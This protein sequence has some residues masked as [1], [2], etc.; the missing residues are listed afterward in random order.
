MQAGAYYY[1]LLSPEKLL[2][3]DV[4][5]PKG[6]WMICCLHGHKELLAGRE[7]IGGALFHD[8]GREEGVKQKKILFRS[9]FWRIYGSDR[10]LEFL[11]SRDSEEIFV[12]Q[13]D[14]FEEGTCIKTDWLVW[15]ETRQG[16]WWGRSSGQMP[17]Y[18]FT[19]SLSLKEISLLASIQPEF[20]FLFYL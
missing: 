1:C 18:Y 16:M 20:V 9:C 7:I 13:E 2:P 5:I 3:A 8:G 4:T 14:V 6:W 19:F 17:F 11:K 12:S 10:F 15:G